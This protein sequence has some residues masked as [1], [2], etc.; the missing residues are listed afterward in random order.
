MMTYRIYCLPAFIRLHTDTSKLLDSQAGMVNFFSRLL[1]M[2]T[3]LNLDNFFC[4]SQI[5]TFHRCSVKAKMKVIMKVPTTP[6]MLQVTQTYMTA[7]AQLPQLYTFSCNIT[8]LFVR[9]P[10]LLFLIIGFHVSGIQKTVNLSASGPWF[11]HYSD[12]DN[13]DEHWIEW[14]RVDEVVAEAEQVEPSITFP[15]IDWEAL[16]S[17]D[18]DVDEN[19]RGSAG[20]TGV[21]A[22]AIKRCKVVSIVIAVTLT[23]SMK[24]YSSYIV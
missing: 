1:V 5:L 21:P 8:T 23:I 7:N 10:D 13:D 12:V 2:F 11:P 18:D 15:F 22:S 17:I 3:V 19:S 20:K 6:T 4:V 9:K 24:V 16:E 14:D